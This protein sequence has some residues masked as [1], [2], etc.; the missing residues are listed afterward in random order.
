[1]RTKLSATNAYIIPTSSPLTSNSRKNSMPILLH[2]AS[3][4]W[5]CR[6][7]VCDSRFGHVH[8]VHELDGKGVFDLRL[9][10]IL[11]GDDR[12]HLDLWPL[13]IKGFEDILVFLA[14]IAASNL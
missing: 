5:P 14:D 7:D 1:M 6:S 3:G 10:A 4:T 12:L 13:I 8:H 9:A 2:Q 11:V